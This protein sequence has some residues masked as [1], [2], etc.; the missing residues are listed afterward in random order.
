MRIKPPLR[1]AFLLA[2]PAMLA[3]CSS[4]APEGDIVNLQPG[5]HKVYSFEADA[6]MMVSFSH[7]GD[8]D[9]ALGCQGPRVD[10]MAFPLPNCAGVYES[11]GKNIVSGGT[12]AEGLHGAGVGFEPVNGKITVA[13]K[14]ISKI[15]LELSI[16][17]KPV[18]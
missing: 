5:E 16:E 15:P 10:P 1:S 4:G 12:Y 13:L 17:T 2:S 3:A 18:G 8:S 11:D 7:E 6:P 9:T 14:N